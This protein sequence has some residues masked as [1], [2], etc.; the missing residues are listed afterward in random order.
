MRLVH[1]DD[2]IASA[3]GVK[4]RIVTPLSALV[5]SRGR[6]RGLPSD[7]RV[8][9]CQVLVPVFLALDQAFRSLCARPSLSCVPVKRID[10]ATPQVG[11][12]Q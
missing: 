3:C 10:A 12:C 2:R 6:L 4:A 9:I 8:S 7:W 11:L 5:G 1:L